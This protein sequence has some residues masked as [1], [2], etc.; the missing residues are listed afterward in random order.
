MKIASQSRL[1]VIHSHPRQKGFWSNMS[2]LILTRY[3]GWDQVEMM[4]TLQR[5]T[6]TTMAM[7]CMATTQAWSQE[8]IPDGDFETNT[9]VDAPV[10]STNPPGF[11]SGGFFIRED[12]GGNRF[13]QF[14]TNVA[15]SGTLATNVAAVVVDQA[16]QVTFY[17][18]RTG[19]QNS[20]QVSFGGGGPAGVRNVN[21]TETGNFFVLRFRSAVTASR[22]TFNIT[23]PAGGGTLSIDNISLQ[24]VVPELNAASATLPFALALSGMMLA[25]DRR[26]ASAVATV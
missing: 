15:A 5:A 21:V 2:T 24:A 7:L 12:A 26:R 1:G 9:T 3:Y 25:Y 10:S 19:G 20:L 16:Y 17:A 4:R 18:E 8:L 13:A 6:V 11:A 22:V 23:Q 14:S